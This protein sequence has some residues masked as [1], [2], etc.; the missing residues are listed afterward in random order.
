MMEKAQATLEKLSQDKAFAHQALAREIFLHDQASRIH[1]AHQ[2]GRQEEQR[3]I[4]QAMLDKG[5]AAEMIAELTRLLLA[6]VLQ[7]KK[8][9]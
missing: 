3:A 2:K 8:A 9:Y 1:E 6:E 5:M 4:A 7:F